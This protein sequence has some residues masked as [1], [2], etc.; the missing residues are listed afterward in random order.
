MMKTK[1]MT[2]YI[3]LFHYFRGKAGKSCMHEALIT[4]IWYIRL[5]LSFA[6]IY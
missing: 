5:Q 3:K 4:V 1:V 2:I 6:L